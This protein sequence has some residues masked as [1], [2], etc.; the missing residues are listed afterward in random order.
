MKKFLMMAAFL[1]TSLMYGTVTH[2]EE[3]AKS[4]EK[5]KAKIEEKKVE[6]DKKKEEKKDEKKKEEP[7]KAE[8]KK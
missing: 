3:S 1:A 8:E 6:K 7:K 2:A 4:L 5:D